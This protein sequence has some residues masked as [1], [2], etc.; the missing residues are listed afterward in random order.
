M[1][2]IDKAVLIGLLVT[3]SVILLLMINELIKA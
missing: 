2:S 3:L 1:M